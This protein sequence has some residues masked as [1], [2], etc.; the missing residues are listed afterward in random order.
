MRWY[1]CVLMKYE[2]LSLLSDKN[3]MQVFELRQ[4]LVNTELSY[5]KREAGGYH[6]ELNRFWDTFLLDFL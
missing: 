2:I 5:L 4:T 6:A 3:K 1:L